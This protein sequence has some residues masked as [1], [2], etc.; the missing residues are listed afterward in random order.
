MFRRT[1]IISSLFIALVGTSVWA[2]GVR[3]NAGPRERQGPGIARLVERLNLTEVQ[4]NGIRALQQTRQQEMRS[5]QDEMR[6]KRQALRE[7]MQQQN[8]NPADVG[9]A[10][11]ALRELRERRRSINERFLSG[12]RALL[13]P[14]QLE[15]LP[16]R[17]R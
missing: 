17:L 10:T 12:I 8:P 11:L 9:N 4:K 2:Q 13:T 7:L 16:R 3:R 14:E 1:I 5:L 15:Q 6:Q